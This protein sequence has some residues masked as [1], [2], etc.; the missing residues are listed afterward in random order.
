VDTDK[1]VSRQH[2]IELHEYFAV[3]FYW[4]GGELWGSVPYPG[5]L[6]TPDPK[7]HARP[8][9]SPEPAATSDADP[10]LR[11]ARMVTGYFVQAVDDEIGHVE[12]FLLDSLS[13]AIRWL[14][15]DTRNVLPGKRVLVSPARIMWVSWLEL[16]VHIGLSRA[17]IARVAKGLGLR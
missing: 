13:W 12:D 3:P 16:K 9:P 6:R 7:P 17:T 2:E 14:V 11:S 5:I 15:V 4:T 8:R 1:P 10:H